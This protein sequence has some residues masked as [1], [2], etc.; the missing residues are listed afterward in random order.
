MSDELIETTD[1]C[2]YCGELISVLLDSAEIGQE[3]IEDCQVCCRPIVFVVQ[4]SGD[5]QLQLYLRSENDTF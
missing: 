3:Y 5:G 4:S 2:P 1:Y